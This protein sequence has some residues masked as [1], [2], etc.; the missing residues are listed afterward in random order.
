[1]GSYTSAPLL[2]FL[3]VLFDGFWFRLLL[4]GWD[5]CRVGLVTEPFRVPLSQW[6]VCRH[7]H[8]CKSRFLALYSQ[9]EHGSWTSPWF[10]A[11]VTTVYTTDLGVASCGSTDYRHRHG[12]LPLHGLDTII[13]LSGSLA[14][15]HQ[16]DF[17]PHHP[18]QIS[19]WPLVETR[20][21][22]IDTDSS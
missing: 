13:S 6:R 19:T 14:H 7:Q 3:T 18:L 9:Q 17:Q 8:H 16:H 22:D 10:L 4:L 5:R 20:A 2:Q 15:R 11:T 12:P 21:K 1:M